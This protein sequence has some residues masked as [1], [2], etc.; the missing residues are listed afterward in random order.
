MVHSE[1]RIAI[2]YTFS[3]H[4]ALKRPLAVLNLNC[5]PRH[6]VAYCFILSPKSDPK[7]NPKSLIKMLFQGHHWKTV[8]FNP[9]LDPYAI[10]IL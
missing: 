5:K 9:H 10:I 4:C 1:F 2:G 8:G 3:P 6:L 7:L